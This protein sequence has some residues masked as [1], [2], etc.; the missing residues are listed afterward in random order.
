MRIQSAAFDFDLPQERIAQRPRPYE[1]QRLLVY[2]R[3]SRAIRHRVFSDLPGL[4]RAGDLL[5]VNDSKV[6]PAQ[7]GWKDGTSIL[8]MEPTAAGFDDLRAICPSKPE[9]GDR[10][11]LPGA[12]FVV[13][14]KEEL[15][16][17]R[18]GDLIPDEPFESL[19]AFLEACGSPPLPPYVQR[20]PDAR[21]A[22]D[23]QTMFAAAP[24]SIAAPTAG[25]HF[26]P[27]LVSALEAQGVDVATIT[28]HVGYGT[29]RQF[30]SEYVD[31]HTMDTEWYRVS[32]AAAGAIWRALREGRRVIG[33]GTTATRTVETIAPHVRTAASPQGL[34]G[35]ATLF[36]YPPYRFQVVSG[37]ITNFHYPRTPVMSL[38]AAFCGGVDQLHR[39]YREAL[40]HDYQFYSYGDAM[41]A[42]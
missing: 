3:A 32:A 31:E 15:S 28:L 42:V 13:K 6:V 30:H 33:V 22:Q 8:L 26:H 37:L 16:D 39:I 9:V 2:D 41:L 36:I 10:L 29:F 19:I 18:V 5:V 35:K 7:L 27:A 20:E 4:L 38:T 1:E 11:E 24:G 17:L 14:A 34:A 21:D 40:A 25:L 12:T 23:Y